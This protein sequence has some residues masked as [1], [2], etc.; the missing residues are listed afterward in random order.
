MIHPI[1]LLLIGAPSGGKSDG[2]LKVQRQPPKLHHSKL[3]T[4]RERGITGSDISGEAA[5]PS[6]PG[7]MEHAA[8]VLHTS[9]GRLKA[10]NTFSQGFRNSSGIKTRLNSI[11]VLSLSVYR[12]IIII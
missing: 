7:L 9:N 6:W 1:H 4:I 11:I 2:F 12:Q 10:A 8:S 5:G 3:C